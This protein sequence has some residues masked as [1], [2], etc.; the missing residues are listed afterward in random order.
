MTDEIGYVWQRVAADIERRI[1]SGELPPGSMLRGE[2]A[3][4]EEYGVAIDTVRRAV[5]DLRE[6]GIVVTLPAK[7]TYVAPRAVLC[8]APPWEPMASHAS[9]R[10]PMGCHRVAMREIDRSL[11]MPPWQ[12][13]AAHIEADIRAGKY[14]P[15]DRLPSIVT[16]T[17]QY[18]VNRKTAHKALLSLV[19]RGLIEA[20]P[21]MGYYVRPG[22]NGS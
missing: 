11:R 21:G 14:G 12:Q 20:E 5:K 15:D 4:A 18:E 13:I 2:R 3:M 19:E 17:Q 22:K 16:L 9:G 7:G 8:R 10:S 6:R 1:D